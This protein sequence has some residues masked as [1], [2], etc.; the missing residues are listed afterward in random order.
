MRS[1]PCKMEWRIESICTLDWPKLT[2]YSFPATFN[3][4]SRGVEMYVLLCISGIGSKEHTHTHKKNPTGFRDL[5][6]LQNK[7]TEILLSPPNLFI[8]SMWGSDHCEG[9]DPGFCILPEVNFFYSPL[10]I[11]TS[12]QLLDSNSF[13][14]W[15]TSCYYSPGT[16]GLQWVGHI[17]WDGFF[18]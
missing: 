12:Y 14:R 3:W 2:F 16:H 18:F 17:C 10:P 4:K 5:Y 9:R 8:V 1:S 6:F 13:S 15:Y 11:G 7:A